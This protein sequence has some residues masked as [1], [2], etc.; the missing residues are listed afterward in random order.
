MILFQMLPRNERRYLYNMLRSEGF[1]HISLQSLCFLPFVLFALF[2][3]TIWWD[4]GTQECL[5]AQRIHKK[6]ITDVFSLSHS[7]RLTRILNSWVSH[8]MFSC[9]SF[10]S[11]CN[12]LL[13]EIPALNIVLCIFKAPLGGLAMWILLARNQEPQDTLQMK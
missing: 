11:R 4:R 1:M 10:Y 9:L 7:Y 3:Q 2:L 6:R 5:C 12:S 8:W 13:G